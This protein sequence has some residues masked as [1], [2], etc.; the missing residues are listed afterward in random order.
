MAFPSPPSRPALPARPSPAARPSRPAP[1]RPSGAL[2]FALALSA[3]SLVPLAAPPL[4]RADDAAVAEARARFDEGITL[5]DAGRNEEARLK[6]TQA[7]AVLKA[8]ALLFNLARVEQLTGHDLDALEHYL[9]FLRIAENDAKVTDATREK[10]RAWIAELAK[11]AGRLDVETPAGTRL[12]LD[13]KLVDQPLTEPLYVRPGRHT[14]EGTYQG[15]A[16][17]AMAE[18]AT[19]ETTKVRLDLD[20]APESAPAS[21]TLPPAV[22]PPRGWSTARFVTVSAL[23]AGALVGG[24]LTFVFRGAAQGNVDDARDALGGAGCLGAVGDEP[25]ARAAALRDERD[26]NQT[27]STVSLVSGLVLAGGALGA[28]LLWPEGGGRV[29]VTPPPRLTP[30][31]GTSTA[32]LGLAGR[33]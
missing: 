10:A 8:P 19:G 23:G 17:T 30:V 33:F 22:A 20:R 9:Q 24:V 7:L 13:G 11:K 25:C 15:R 16:R 31:V 27:L 6:F 14:L 5:A 21:T 18:V 4:A 29:G 2:V 26:T 12:T 1:S 3:A 32:G 28:A